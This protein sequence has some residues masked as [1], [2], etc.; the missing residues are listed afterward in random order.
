MKFLITVEGREYGIEKGELTLGRVK[1]ADI[2]IPSRGLSRRHAR[3]FVEAG[4]LKVEDLESR[5]GTFVNGVRVQG[6][7]ELRPGDTVRCADVTCIIRAEAAGQAG[8]EE[9]TKE[10][11][12]VPPE[13]E[14][15]EA[16]AAAEAPGGE[17]GRRRLFLNA[18]AV[19]AAAAAVCVLVFLSPGGG[20]ARRARAVLMSARRVFREVKALSRVSIPARL[21]RGIEEIDDALAS[22]K[23]VPPS[24]A[25]EYEDARALAGLLK[26]VKG[27]LA[28]R[29]LV[30]ENRRSFT[31]KYEEIM[32]RFHSGALPGHK[33]VEELLALA[34]RME[35]TIY[36]KIY[37]H[38]ADSLKERI[39][40]ETKAA[41]RKRIDEAE[42]LCIEEKYGAALACLNRDVGNPYVS[43][44]KAE[45]AAL[46]EEAARVKKKFENAVFSLERDVLRQAELGHCTEAAA[47]LERKF[48]YWNVPGSAGEKERIRTRIE[49]IRTRLFQ[50]SSAHIK[51]D[52]EEARK[53]LDKRFYAKAARKFA[54]LLDLVDNKDL[55]AYIDRRR[56]TTLLLKKL[57]ERLVARINGGKG[58]FVPFAGCEGR[59]VKADNEKFYVDVEGGTVGFK[60]GVMTDDEFARALTTVLA[61]DGEALLGAGILLRRMDERLGGREIKKAAELDPKLR[62]A[63]AWIYDE[64]PPVFDEEDVKAALADIRWRDSRRVYDKRGANPGKVVPEETAWNGIGV[65]WR[66]EGDAN[67]NALVTV[68]Y[69]KRGAKKWNQGMR[70]RPVESSGEEEGARSVLYAGGVLSVPP[71]GEYELRLRLRDP[72]GG[73]A[74]RRL[75]VK[76]LPRPGGETGKVRRVVPPGR[77]TTEFTDAF[78]GFDLVQIALR[79]GDTV[80]LHKGVYPSLMVRKSGE[81][82]RPIVW[83]AAGDGEV[84]IDGGG[85]SA[86]INARRVRHVRFE[87][88]TIR[89]AFAGVDLSGASDVAVTR[90]RFSDCRCCV[91]AAV[92]PRAP[93]M[94]H[95]YIADNVFI[96]PYTW[97]KKD[98][99]KKKERLRAVLIGG[100]GHTVEHNR[101]RGFGIGISL[102]P[103]SPL[104]SI[105]IRNNDIAECLFS[106]VDVSYCEAHVR[107]LGN[108]ITNCAAGVSMDSVKGG[109]VYVARNVLY[110]IQGEPWSIGRDVSGVFLLHNTS[111]RRGSPFFARRGVFRNVVVKNNLF[112]GTACRYALEYAA[113]GPGCF[114]DYNGYGGAWSF[115]ALA[116]GKVYATIGKFREETG[117]EIHGKALRG[118]LFEGGMKPPSEI[119]KAYAPDAL[120]FEPA[121]GSGVIDAACPLPGMN[122][123]YTGRGPDIGACERGVSAPRYGPR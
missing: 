56:R 64:L 83:K 101:I 114:F 89:N 111:V 123:A 65:N 68:E 95:F 72:D 99:L 30:M 26:K 36:E 23:R 91:S 32:N 107:V 37:R 61:Q 73:R 21:S 11:P 50:E 19:A 40:R 2:L 108:R 24:C 84:V 27:E 85:E 94:K 51:Y 3:F 1:D 47:E 75:T 79:P 6:T 42:N 45:M 59:V 7:I 117:M 60:W 63:Y 109:P 44:Y 46:A 120:R 116:G 18:A 57:K 43:E 29:L 113:G 54:D 69:R 5:N 34:R 121:A 66:V 105:E 90:C 78:S 12:S 35:G 17:R 31:R 48:A 102:F 86:A 103:G 9:D 16:P 93:V 33:A 119:E 115:F 22:L 81:E 58:G 62:E 80:L 52:M 15:R 98:A 53:C 100:E 38:K 71:G 20:E 122:D 76:T 104:R 112:V 82:G 110:N 55:R 25:V 87:G 28:D 67:R 8:R 92:D 70:M 39:I 88:L 10:S 97:E 118:G 13:P 96:G 106:A 74:E 49:N 14:T 77:A 4:V 41:L